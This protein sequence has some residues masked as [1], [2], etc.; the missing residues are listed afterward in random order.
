MGYT[1]SKYNTIIEKSGKIIAF[2]SLSR[3]MIRLPKEKFNTNNPF[4]IDKGFAV[5]DNEDFLT[6]KYYYLSRIFDDKTINLSIATTMSCN[7]KCPY[8]FEEG[9]KSQEFMSEEISDSIVKY[10]VSKRNHNINITWFGGEPLINFKAIERISS[11]LKSNNIVFS[12]TIITN[13][14]LFT[15]EMIKKLNS[16]SIKSVQITLDGRQ[17]QHDTKRFF[18]NGKGTY[19]KIFENINLL[20]H[21][22]N[23][24]VLIKVNLDKTNV[25]SYYDLQNEIQKSFNEYTE[26]GRLKV[27]RNYVRNRNEF[28]GCE[29]CMSEEDYFDKFY[30]PKHALNYITNIVA[31]CPLRSRSDFAIGPDGS[32]YKCLELLG[33]KDKSI[34]NILTYKI[35]LRKQARYALSYS[36][37]D[38]EECCN[39]EIFP[40][41][42]GGCPIDRERASKENK[43]NEC[44]IIKKRIKQIIEDY[45]VL[46]DNNT[47]SKK[48]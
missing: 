2:N 1:L 11:S 21:L 18:A 44:A 15:K 5:I 25:E 41:C 13:G 22:S 47:N 38:D 34:G 36:P 6:Y 20:L 39:C 43:H 7:L 35:D 48:Q 9:N 3:T 30:N 17:S 28:K 33:S 23:I 8:C 32:I 26:S 37:F 12:A 19:T 45:L 29:T 10:L 24:N 42:G 4:I 40:L 27:T 14:T 31:P 46:Q 16:Y